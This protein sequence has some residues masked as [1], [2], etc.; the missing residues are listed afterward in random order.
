M[1]DENGVVIYSGLE[2]AAKATLDLLSKSLFFCD[3]I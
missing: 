1:E 2:A 3:F